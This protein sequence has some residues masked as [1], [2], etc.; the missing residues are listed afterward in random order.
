MIDKTYE[1]CHEHLREVGRKR[2]QLLVFYTIVIGAYFSSLDKIDPELKPPFAI[3]VAVFGIAVSITAVLL[4]SWHL[5]YVHTIKLLSDRKDIEL[6]PSFMEDETKKRLGNLGI[7]TRLL[8]WKWL[9]R[10][11][12]G[13]EFFTMNSFLVITFLPIYAIM[14]EMNLGLLFSRNPYL[15][16]FVDLLIYLLVANFLSAWYLYKD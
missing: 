16:F 9:K 1:E 2:D 4:R 13:V 14:L 8:T 7:S 3:A 6:S 11:S 10:Y 12:S 15:T 5:R